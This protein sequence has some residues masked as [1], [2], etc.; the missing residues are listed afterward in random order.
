MRWILLPVLLITHLTWAYAQSTGHGLNEED[1]LRIQDAKQQYYTLEFRGCNN[2]PLSFIISPSSYYH[3]ILDTYVGSINVVNGGSSF[4]LFEVDLRKAFNMDHSPEDR[5]RPRLYKIDYA[6]KCDGFVTIR[7]LAAQEFTINAPGQGAKISLDASEIEDLNVSNTKTLDLSIISGRYKNIVVEESRNISFNIENTVES[8]KF[9]DVSIAKFNCLGDVPKF[10]SFNNVKFDQGS[11]TIDLTT[12]SKND[13]IN[14]IAFGNTDINHFNFDYMLFDLDR[15]YMIDEFD[16]ST[17]QLSNIYYDILQM[18]KR[19]GYLDGEKKIGSEMAEFVYLSHGDY[20]TNFIQKYF[21]GYG[22]NKF[23]LFRY[24][25]AIWL[26]FAILNTCFR[27]KLLY[28][29]YVIEQF[30]EIDSEWSR[31]KIAGLK[32]FALRFFNMFIYTGFLF[33]GIKVNL[34]RLKFKP[35]WLALFV[36]LQYCTG[37]FFLTII[38]N[39]IISG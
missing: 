14:K 11:E 19:Y 2:S 26:C 16:L 38:L 15:E 9:E 35:Y 24:I 37:I 34:E 27:K 13:Y 31:R 23:L 33:W 25:L 4:H 18:Q 17:S 10:I 30:R 22:Y 28:Q 39:K 5:R 21:W 7:G 29:T 36:V 20:F 6:L 12:S 32:S 1:I 3:G 8:I